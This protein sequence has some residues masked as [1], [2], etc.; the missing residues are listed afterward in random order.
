MRRTEQDDV[1]DNGDFSR[2]TGLTGSAVIQWSLPGVM[3]MKDQSYKTQRTAIPPVQRPASN[4]Q[5]SSRAFAIV[6]PWRRRSVCPPSRRQFQS[7]QIQT[8]IDV[9]AL[10][11]TFRVGCK[12]TDATFHLESPHNTVFFVSLVVFALFR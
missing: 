5:T 9:T 7:A 4:C 10:D 8:P 12:F 3:P 11:F 6:P 2:G 1:D